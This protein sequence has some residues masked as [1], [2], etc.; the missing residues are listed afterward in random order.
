ML[1]IYKYIE[2]YKSRRILAF[3]NLATV[4]VAVSCKKLLIPWQSFHLS[5]C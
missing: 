4:E 5:G 2:R 3:F 1:F